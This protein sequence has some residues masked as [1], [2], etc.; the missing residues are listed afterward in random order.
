MG[1]SSL[2]GPK[3]PKRSIICSAGVGVQSHAAIWPWE[4]RP[5]VARSYS[6]PSARNS[7]VGFPEP[8]LHCWPS[9]SRIS[10]VVL[11]RS[12]FRRTSI[13]TSRKGCQCSRSTRGSPSASCRS[14][15]WQMTSA[16]ML[17]PK[18]YSSV[19]VD[20]AAG[21]T[22]F[23]LGEELTKQV[24]SAFLDVSGSPLFARRSVH[25]SAGRSGGTSDQMRQQL[26]CRP[27]RRGRHRCL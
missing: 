17:G 18:I 13:I 1:W 19:R 21:P 7:V 26:V 11:C 8:Q 15:S 5:C 22:R 16:A 3:N 12:C 20:S 24:T 14:A 2:R 23:P 25:P 9:S 10:R 4:R 27:S 6:Y